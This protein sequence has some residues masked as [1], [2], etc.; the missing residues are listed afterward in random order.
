MRQ[1]KANA[2]PQSKSGTDPLQGRS[3]FKLWCHE[4][5]KKQKACQ[6]G[7]WD[8]N[9]DKQIG[10]TNHE[11]VVY[12]ADLR[13]K[14]NADIMLLLRPS[15]RVIVRWLG[16]LNDLNG[17]NLLGASGDSCI[18]RKHQTHKLV[19]PAKDKRPSKHIECIWPYSSSFK[20]M[21]GRDILGEKES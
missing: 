20:K 13:L 21:E 18:N 9:A 16:P 4:K 15:G 1:W 7:N 2:N 12:L 5:E 8:T 6:R 19:S 14:K 11:E 17:D 3:A 10:E